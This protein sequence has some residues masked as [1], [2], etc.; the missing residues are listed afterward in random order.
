MPAV[1]ITDLV[2][3]AAALAAD[4]TALANRAAGAAQDLRYQS[5]GLDEAL[6]RLSDALGMEDSR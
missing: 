4:L 2:D 3:R 5:V 1:R 6:C